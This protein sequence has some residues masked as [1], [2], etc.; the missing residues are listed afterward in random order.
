[1]QTRK[2]KRYPLHTANSDSMT[3]HRWWIRMV[4]QLGFIVLAKGKGHTLKVAAYKKSFQNLIKTIEAVR[5]EY[6]EP[7]RKRDLDIIHKKATYLYEFVKN[8][9]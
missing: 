9:I 2:Q 5:K 7:D 4:E 3:I 1:M 8:T 6:T